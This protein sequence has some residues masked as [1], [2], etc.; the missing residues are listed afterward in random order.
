MFACMLMAASS[1]VLP[2]LPTGGILLSF[3]TEALPDA[4][5]LWSSATML[6]DT[7]MQRLTLPKHP[8][9]ILAPQSQP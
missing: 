8:K 2:L 6:P 3:Q 7:W 5:H 9:G 1:S 4:A